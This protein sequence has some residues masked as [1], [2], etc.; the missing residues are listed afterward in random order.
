MP[1]SPNHSSSSH[2]PL[3]IPFLLFLIREHLPLT[4]EAM[5][6]IKLL[7]SSIPKR[8]LKLRLSL[9]NSKIACRI[10]V[11][12]HHFPLLH[13]RHISQYLTV[14]PTLPVLV[15]SVGVRLNT[16]TKNKK[17]FWGGISCSRYLPSANSTPDE[18][19]VCLDGSEAGH[20]FRALC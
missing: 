6:V 9:R 4:G 19:K 15:T 5:S 2:H 10:F 7:L 18:A 20:F 12:N 17:M 1:D 8:L 13:L 3:N 14:P 11:Q 16:G